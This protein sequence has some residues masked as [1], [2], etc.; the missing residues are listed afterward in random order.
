MVSRA[1]R[2]GRRIVLVCDG[3]SFHKTKK[4][5]AYLPTVA[6]FLTVFWL[7]A[8]SPDLNL[9][10][11]LWGHVKRSHVANVLFRSQFELHH[12]LT[13]VFAKLNRR[14]GHV[15][16]VVFNTRKVA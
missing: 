13:D 7:P 8:Y 11:R 9:I 2:T 14:R 5:L 15:L 6:P 16:N 1:K 4:M 3:P 12:V 10:E